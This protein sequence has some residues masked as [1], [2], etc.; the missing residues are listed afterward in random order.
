[1]RPDQ[2]DFQGTS[3]TIEVARKLGVPAM[4][5][6]INKAPEALNFD[7]LKARAEQIYNVSVATILPH[8]EEMMMLASAGIFTLLY[9]DHPVA[10]K[11][12]QVAQL[13]MA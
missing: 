10:I 1:M 7:E 12:K 8:S 4:F 13:L 5:L 2:Q 3:V 9:P 11:Y 6:V